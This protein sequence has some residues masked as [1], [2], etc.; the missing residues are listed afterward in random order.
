MRMW[1]VDPSI[2][3]RKHLLGEHVECHMFLGALRKNKNL[4]GYLDNNLFEPNFLFDRH[5][6]LAEEMK[7][8]GYNHKSKLRREDLSGLTL[9]DTKINKDKS[10]SDLLS[11][12]KVCNSRYSIKVGE[13]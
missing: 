6:A 4:Q 3:C 13:E 9:A 10:L 12:C 8:R 1:M 11:R 5:K 7:R 2:M